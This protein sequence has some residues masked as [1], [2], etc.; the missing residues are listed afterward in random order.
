[1]TSITLPDSLTT[2]GDKA[3]YYC[4]GLTSITLPNTLT[5]I[6]ISA[7][8]NC[9]AL[10]SVD[11]PNSVTTIGNQAFNYCTSMTSANIGNS[12]TTIDGY[13]FKACKALV[14]VNLTSN[15]VESIGNEAFCDCR[16]LKDFYSSISNPMNVK[17][18]SDVFENVP[19]GSC[20]LW[21]PSGSKTLY[22]SVEQW[23]AFSNI[24]E[25]G[26]IDGDVNG[27]GNVDIADVNCVI[28]VILGS[29]AA[30]IDGD[31]NGDGTVD[32]ADVNAIINII[33]G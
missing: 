23:N 5:T 7:F 4:T 14:S 10:T 19:T 21:V 29:G 11:I 9:T 22:K 25:M 18:G 1:M 26:G 17:M 24:N 15:L 12:V 8:N 13:A 32:I 6:G 20:T 30:G 3:F 27:D 16:E 31:V 2:I 28:N 33:L